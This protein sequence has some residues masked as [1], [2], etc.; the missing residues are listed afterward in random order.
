MTD[1]S[2]NAP[3]RFLGEVQTQMVT[4]D[5]S[6]AQTV[7]VGSP[8]IVDQSGD[9]AHAVAWTSSITLHA[10]D[11]FLG[12]ATEAKAVA[13][14]DAETE[15]ITIAGHDSIVGFKSA[16]FSD[17]ADLGKTVYMDDSA[18]LTATNTG[19]L[20][21]GKLVRVLDGFAYVKLSAPQIQDALS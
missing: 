3:I 16:V 7:Y 20:K 14:G 5:S 12:I 10:T 8:I 15:Y 18:V 13:S 9:T 21:I 2:A 19:N 11:V 1:L 6:A 4:L 17:Y